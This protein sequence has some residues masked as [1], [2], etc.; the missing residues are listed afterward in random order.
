MILLQ[1]LEL[2]VHILWQIKKYCIKMNILWRNKN[3]F[4]GQDKKEM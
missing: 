2:T 1:W 4:I 3:G